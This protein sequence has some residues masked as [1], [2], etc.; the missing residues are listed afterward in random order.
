[1]PDTQEAP[2]SLHYRKI[3]TSEIRRQMKSCHTIF[4]TCSFNQQL[5]SVTVLEDEVPQVNGHCSGR[6]QNPVIGPG[7]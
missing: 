6:T 3:N 7:C 2:G 5:N 1:M 4:R